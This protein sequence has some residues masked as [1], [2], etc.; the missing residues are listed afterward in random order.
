MGVV[1]RVAKRGL[2]S[3][4]NWRLNKSLEPEPLP[5]KPESDTGSLPPI[6]GLPMEISVLP[7]KAVR[8]LLGSD[9]VDLHHISDAP[10]PQKCSSRDVFAKAVKEYEEHCVDFLLKPILPGIVD[11]VDE[12]GATLTQLFRDPQ[13]VVEAWPLMHRGQ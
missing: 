6:P 4:E 11:E 3:G 9:L 12:S 8:R 7:F 5:A 2:F 13:P 10:D 1:A